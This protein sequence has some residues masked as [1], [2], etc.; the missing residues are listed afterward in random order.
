MNIEYNRNSIF[1]K[2]FLLFGFL[3]WFGI[4]DQVKAQISQ[5]GTPLSFSIKL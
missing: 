1:I 3:L 5:G 2:K 4:S